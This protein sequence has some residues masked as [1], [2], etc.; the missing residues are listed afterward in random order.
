MQCQELKQL[1]PQPKPPLPDRPEYLDRPLLPVCQRHVTA[2]GQVLDDAGEPL[3]GVLISDGEHV[4]TTD[5]RGKYQLEF[6]LRELRIISVTRPRGYRPGDCW[7]RIIPP[8]EQRSEYHHDF[9]FARDALA[10]R[11]AFNFLSAGDTQFADLLSFV[12][13]LEEFDHFTRMSGEPGFFTN[14]GDVTMTGCQWEM[15]MY[16]EVRA[17]SHLEVYDIFGG[18]DGN[19]ALDEKGHGSVYNYQINLGPAWYSWDY[20]PVHFASY[21]SEEAY[22]TERELAMQSTWLEAD[23]AAQ[24]AG[25]P[26]VVTTHIPPPNEVMEDWLQR[27]NIIGLLFGH[28]HTIQTCGYGGVPYLDTGPMRGRD[29][30]TFSRLFRVVSYA[31]GELT[32]ETRVCGQMQRLEIVAPQQV[33]GRGTVPVQAKAYDTIRRVTDVTCHIATEGRAVEVPL[34]RS[35]AWTWEGTWDSAKAGS[36]FE[37]FATARDED[38]RTWEKTY[39]GEVSDRPAVEVHIGDDWPGFFR[40]EHSR[41]REQPLEPPLELAWTAN[42][43]G[44]NMKAVSPIVYQGR[45]CVGVEHKEIG[46]PHAAVCCHDPA[47]GTLLW[48]TPLDASINFGLAAGHGLIYAIDT[49]G[50][51]YG[52]DAETGTERWRTEP[53]P[54]EFGRSDIRGC[55]LL[56]GDQLLV[57]SDYSHTAFLD[58]VSGEQLRAMRPSDEQMYYTF[59]TMHRG[60]L[61]VPCFSG[62]IIACDAHSGE[63]IWVGRTAAKAPTCPVPYRGGVYVNCG[64]PGGFSCLDEDTGERRWEGEMPRA[65][66]CISAAVPAG[67]LVLANSSSLCAFEAASGEPRWR[68]EFVYDVASARHNQR[69]EFGG[70]STPLVAADVV[71]VGADDGH[72]YAFALDDGEFLWRCNLGVPL[73]G[74]PVVSGNALFICDWD[75]NLYCFAGIRRQETERR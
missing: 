5:S 11:D 50:T 32:S 16:R 38:W 65:L 56:Y 22:I 54:L 10:D 30:G 8:D 21:V 3:G 43:G 74:S 42:I 61:L 2:T 62:K 13:L 72:L 66:V 9:V 63:E 37:V 26:I 64:R 14:A 31:D 25:K 34:I 53:F 24:P 15:D 70:M 45:V 73:K 23:L 58:P 1:Q 17:R 19:Y 20:G 18:H 68:H 6:D 51:C 39:I 28:W 48:R 35:G 57:V 59:A 29:W 71:Y 55:P 40:I 27:Y 69:Q 44:R 47:T 12:Y 75:G 4:T 33:V 46:H 41:V 49:M 52:I 60:Q 67:D 7:Y 36:E